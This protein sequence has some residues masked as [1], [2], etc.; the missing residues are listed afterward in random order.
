MAIKKT[1]AKQKLASKEESKTTIPGLSRKNLIEFARLDIEKDELTRKL[2]DVE[3]R[4]KMKQAE[5]L[6]AFEQL[7]TDSVKFAG[8]SVYTFKQLWA[9]PQEGVL[10]SEVIVALKKHGFKD[11]VAENYN[12]QSLSARMR[13][14]EQQYLEMHMQKSKEGRKPFRFVDYLPKPLVKVLKLEP[15]FSIRIHG[16][17]P[18]EVLDKLEEEVKEHGD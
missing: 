18:T 14:L 11:Y 7:G 10:R 16:T 12:V 4:H 5:I 13:E 6:A 8:H 9:R 15:D 3:K 17:I 1:P 2:K